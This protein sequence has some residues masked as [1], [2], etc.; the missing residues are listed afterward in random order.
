LWING[1]D[2]HNIERAVEQR[3]RVESGGIKKGFPPQT[4]QKPLTDDNRGG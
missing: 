1:V 4:A 3:S 2:E